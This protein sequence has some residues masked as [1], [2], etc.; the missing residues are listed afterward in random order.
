MSSYFFGKNVADKTL[1]VF[2]VTFRRCVDYIFK[3]H[4]TLAITYF[5]YWALN[6]DQQR[7][8][9]KQI[10]YLV[11]C[12]FPSSPWE[13]RKTEYAGNCNL[14]FVDM[15][16]SDHAR[17]FV[18]NPLLL[19]ERLD[20]FNFVVWT[21]TSSTHEKP[22]LRVMLE[23]SGIPIDQYP[24]AVQTIGGLLRLPY[25]TRESAVVTQPMFLPSVF[26]GHCDAIFDDPLLATH[27]DGR[28]FTKEDIAKDEASLPPLRSKNKPATAD[29]IAADTE[30]DSLRYLA[31]RDTRFTIQMAKDALRFIS[32]TC[33]RDQWVDI[34]SALRHQFTAEQ[35]DE[36]FEAFDAWSSTGENYV[37]RADCATNWRSLQEVPRG[38]APIRIG[39]LIKR[40]QEGGWKYPA[41]SNGTVQAPADLP[42]LP[43]II[44]CNAL[45]KAQLAKPRPIQL[46]EGMLHIGEKGLLAGASKSNKSWTLLDMAVSIATG[47][48]F[49][50]MKTIKGRVLLLNYEINSWFYADRVNKV[51]QAK[52]VVVEDEMLEVW[53]LRGHRASF[54]RVLFELQVRLITETYA[55]VVIDPLYSGLAGRSEND[56]AEM[57]LFM[58][59]IEKL[60]ECGPAVALGHHFAK[61]NSA[62]RESLDRASGSG[63]FARDPDCIVTL[64]RHQTEG[65]FVAEFTL[66]NFPPLAPKGLKLKFP[67]LIPDGTL[68]VEQI[69]GAQV[70][71]KSAVTVEAI[72]AL[73]P[74]SGGIKTAE[75]L[76]VAHEETGVSP[77]RFYALLS[78]AKKQGLIRKAGTLNERA[79]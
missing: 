25:V 40:A 79:Q 47:T 8:A 41:A 52:G 33:A 37:D 39:T 76:E 38:R 77:S 21:T 44:C 66:R 12:T 6:E 42:P 57:A 35:E 3:K 24:E 45:I 32:A 29:R 78:D 50:G 27:F 5:Q 2:N 15:D 58:Q 49:L 59:S 68:N 62:M 7:E 72:V 48:P 31:P 73:L 55:L 75:L 46:I 43:P 61:G 28:A 60:T 26:R 64:N 18:D 71:S 34:A 69:K 13:G 17:Q 10:P 74:N 65:S 54:D 20:G 30:D 22:R 14:I 56:A 11:A 70:R 1:T 67:L 23:A 63:V 36:A 19:S 16:D 51:K 53:N 9:K 4:I